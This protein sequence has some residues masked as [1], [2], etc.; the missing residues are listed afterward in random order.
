MS[1]KYTISELITFI[2]KVRFVN[3]FDNINDN[4]KR[5]KIKDELYKLIAIESI[6]KDCELE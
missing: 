4:V 3:N 2:S 5:E 1:S 6:I